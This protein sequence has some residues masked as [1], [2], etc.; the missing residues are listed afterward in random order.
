MF[1]TFI[2]KG[3]TIQMSAGSLDASYMV[4]MQ[5]GTRAFKT[6]EGAKKYIR[7]CLSDVK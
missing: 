2:Y 3:R 5:H 6:L 4:T 7:K 1:Q